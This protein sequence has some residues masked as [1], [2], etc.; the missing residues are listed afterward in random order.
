VR[1]AFS[2][3][4][5]E[6]SGFSLIELLVV[7]ILLGILAA[8]ALPAFFSQREKAMD[9]RAKSIAHSATIAI[10]SCRV[11]ATNGY[12]SCDAEKL[13]ALEPTLPSGPTLKV[14]GL[15][16][17][18]YTIVVESSP[19]TQVFEVRRNA[20]GKISFPCE[21]QGQGGCPASGFWG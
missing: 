11:E 13:R 2:Q 3:L 18:K 15:G 10:E 20:E 7:M 5:S 8:I 16:E 12:E 14:N 17:D 4:R 21:I 9:S 19:P 6:E 1:A